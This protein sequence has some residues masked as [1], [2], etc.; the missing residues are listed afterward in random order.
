MTATGVNHVSLPVNDI[1]EAVEFVEDVFDLDRIP[2]VNSDAPGV[3]FR[4]G[5]AQLH[6]TERGSSA[7]TIHHFALNVDN[8]AE[9][10]EKVVERDAL[11]GET[12]GSPLYIFPDGTVQMYFRDPSGNLIEVD[13]PDATT[14]PEEIVDRARTREEVLGTDPSNGARTATLF[15]D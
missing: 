9:V 14:L 11:D 15:L 6:L 5:D 2:S 12:F 13:W 4:L 8:F 7:P 1:D 3:W 10:Y